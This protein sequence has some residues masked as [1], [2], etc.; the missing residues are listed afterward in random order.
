MKQETE[1]FDLNLT[2]I[3]FG[4][5]LRQR[6]NVGLGKCCQNDKRRVL[7]QCTQYYYYKKP[8]GQEKI[9]KID[10]R[11]EKKNHWKYLHNCK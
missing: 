9:K 3:E 10:K 4:I 8:Q 6:I 7:N 2:D 11:M 5:D 1:A